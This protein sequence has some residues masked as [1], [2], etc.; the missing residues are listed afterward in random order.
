MHELAAD[1]GMLNEDPGEGRI[2]SLVMGMEEGKRSYKVL[3][4]PPERSSYAQDI[5]W[6]YGVTYQ[7]LIRGSDTIAM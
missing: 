4:R 6:K 1:I 5:A 2:D 7:Q 3:R